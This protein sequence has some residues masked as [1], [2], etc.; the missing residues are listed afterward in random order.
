MEA[1]VPVLRAARVLVTQYPTL[2]REEPEEPAG[3][4]LGV[5][6]AAVAVAVVVLRLLR[7]LGL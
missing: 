3:L 1:L 5:F 7:M 6:P 2:L 4:S